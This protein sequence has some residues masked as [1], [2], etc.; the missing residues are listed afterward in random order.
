MDPSFESSA[1]P[2]VS[3]EKNP[4]THFTSAFLE[5]T[6][7]VMLEFGKDALELHDIVAVWCAI[8]NPHVGGEDID[9]IPKLQKGWAARKRVFDVER[10]GSSF[11]NKMS[12]TPF[13]LSYSTGEVTRGMLVVDR[14]G[15]RG[16]CTPDAIYAAVQAGLERHM[17]IHVPTAIPAQVEIEH[18]EDIHIKGRGVPCIIKTPGSEALL[19]MMLKRVW[20]VS[21]RK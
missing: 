9:G 11:L 14:R 13:H 20:G 6:R 12:L 3:T 1:S 21:E 17:D 7:E 4:V 19:E 10:C 15:D 8:E 18:P 16:A 5:R 2:S